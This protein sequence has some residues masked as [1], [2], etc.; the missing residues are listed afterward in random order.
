MPQFT[1]TISFLLLFLSANLFV[2]SDSSAQQTATEEAT[3]KTTQVYKTVGE[4]KLRIHISKPVDWKATDSRPAVLFFHGGGW[5]GGKPGQFDPH[6]VHLTSRGMVCFQVE[7]RLL[8]KKKTANSDSTPTICIRDA[9]SAMRWVR[10]RAKELGI[11]ADRIGSG[12]GSAGGHLAAFLGTTDGTDDPKDDT[13]VSAR[14]NLMLLFNPVYNNGPGE[15][16]ASR[17]GNRYQEFSPA[18]NISSDDAPSIVFLGSEDK[19]IP[20]SVGQAFQNEMKAKGV[21]SDLRLYGGAGHGFFNQDKEGGKWFAM[22]IEE[23]DEFLV[24]HGWLE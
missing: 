8:K 19:L 18:H 7:Y 13:S 12:G 10:S 21:R 1:E 14:S 24:S 6:C 5:T 22:T 20:I 23:M 3:N 16:G 17:V 15:W 9:K 4:R 11:D 2:T